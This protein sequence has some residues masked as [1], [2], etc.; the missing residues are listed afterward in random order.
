MVC[1]PRPAPSNSWDSKSFGHGTGNNPASQEGD[2]VG[3]RT[4]VNS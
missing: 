2:A 3:L 1:R 4:A